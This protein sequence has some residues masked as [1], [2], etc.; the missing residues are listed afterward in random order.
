MLEL[1]VKILV[2]CHKFD[3][4]VFENDHYMPIHVGKD[5]H[6]EINLG[7]K[8]DNVGDN[9]SNKNNSYCELTALYWA[10]KNM[11]NV[12][13]IGLCHYRRY[14][15]F[16]HKCNWPYSVKSFCLSDKNNVDF[17]IPSDILCKINAGSVLIPKSIHCPYSLYIDYCV[18]H[19]SKDIKI[20]E[21]II[22]EKHECYI[23]AYNYIIK[24]NN[25]I[26]PFNMFVMKWKDFDD[27]CSWIFSIL[28][29]AEKIIDISN[30]DSMQ[31][32]I[33]GFLAERLFNVWIYANKKNVI[34]K[35][36]IL[37]DDNS[38]K[39]QSLIRLLLRNIRNDMIMNLYR[40]K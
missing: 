18:S 23:D 35:P 19:Y 4:V 7:F 1:N 6:P 8:C 26:S 39:E 3:N 34:K 40:L 15:D 11:S 22:S 16:H 2:A 30:Y 33:W 38:V 14:F 5:L 13:I 25:L 9:I 17:S 27:Y 31:S 24:N 12:D 37:F 32:R 21:D 10:W 20:I 29:E 36:V 28:S